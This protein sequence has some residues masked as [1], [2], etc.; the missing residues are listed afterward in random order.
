[1]GSIF[2]SVLQPFNS[3]ISP[4]KVQAMSDGD[5]ATLGLQ[6]DPFPNNN[7]PIHQPFFMSLMIYSGNTNGCQTVNRLKGG[8]MNSINYNLEDQV[9]V[10]TGGSRGIG[11]DIAHPALFLCSAG[12]DFITGQTLLVDGGASA[13]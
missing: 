11:F 1:M 3:R 7:T 9:V 8:P 5:P 13:I 4:N 6:P 2:F 10:V 12:A